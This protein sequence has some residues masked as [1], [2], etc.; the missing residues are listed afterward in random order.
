MACGQCQAEASR[1]GSWRLGCLV[2]LSGAQ[3]E[4]EYATDKIDARAGLW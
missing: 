1:A 3:A 2:G 4:P